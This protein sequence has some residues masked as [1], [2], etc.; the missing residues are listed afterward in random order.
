MDGN[1]SA[2]AAAGEFP[3]E[4]LQ[5]EPTLARVLGAHSGGNHVIVLQAYP[6][7]DVISAASAGV[8]WK[9]SE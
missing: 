3:S 9:P 1:G 2:Q 4:N 7:P 6:D 8:E 5:V